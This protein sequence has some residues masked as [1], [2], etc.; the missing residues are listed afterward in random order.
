MAK[1]MDAV[2]EKVTGNDGKM[3]VPSLAGSCSCSFLSSLSHTLEKRKHLKLSRIS[4]SAPRNTEKED[5]IAQ[6]IKMFHR[7]FYADDHNSPHVPQ[8]R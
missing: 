6:F 3:T 1:V 4:A 8:I 5:P 7:P 2:G